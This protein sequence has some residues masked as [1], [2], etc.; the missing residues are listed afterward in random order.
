MVATRRRSNSVK[1]ALNA[2]EPIQCA[3]APVKKAVW[4]SPAGAL[5]WLVDPLKTGKIVIS[6]VAAWVVCELYK[7]RSNPLTSLFLISHPLPLG[8]ADGSTQRY[9]KG[10]HDFLFLVFYIFVFSFLRQA[11]TEWVLRPLAGR[12][13]LKGES[14][15]ARFLEQAYAAVYFSASSGFGMYV[16]HRQPTWWY[17][18]EYFWLGY[19]HRR[20]DGPLKAYYLLQFAYWLQQ[21]VVLV[22]GLEKPRS[23]FKELILHHLVTTW[24]VGWSYALNL[25]LIGT[26]VFVS[27]DVPD[28][29]LA[30]SKCL[31]YLNFQR[32]SE[33]TF[34]IF[35]GVWHYM[36]HY[37]NILILYSILTE[38]DLIPAYAGSW[39]AEQEGWWILNGFGTGKIP[40]WMKW[41]IFAP[42]L[43]LQVL[44]IVWSA[45]IWGVLYRI[46]KGQK[47][48]D[49]RE[50]GE[51]DE[52]QGESKKR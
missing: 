23:D 19:P 31:N 22:L 18:T 35:I 11:T 32:I 42:L 28:L 45:L 16:M 14:K 49:V 38:F 29:C 41:Q 4:S 7:P 9:A 17:R 13:G 33:L 50:E 12:L 6:I 25:T 30:F 47:P 2:L 8:S 37:L 48:G 36:R 44:N 46:M 15:V 27:M 52:P 39:N 43:A 1:E 40:A 26:A 51:V 24:L 3:A 20:M 34:V 5:S 21:M 10:A